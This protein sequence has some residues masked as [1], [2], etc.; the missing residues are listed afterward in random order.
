MKTT[1]SQISRL[2]RLTIY[3][4]PQKIYSSLFATKYYFYR[5][6]DGCKQF[7]VIDYIGLVSLKSLIKSL[8]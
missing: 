4:N 7:L 3:E 8:S 1:N 6:G 5:H 2:I